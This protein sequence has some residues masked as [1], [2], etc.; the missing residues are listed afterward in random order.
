MHR[1]LSLRRERFRGRGKGLEGGVSSQRPRRPWNVRHLCRRLGEAAY[2]VVQ[3]RT[4]VRI[5]PALRRCHVG[6]LH[7]R[8]QVRD[9]K[10]HTGSFLFLKFSN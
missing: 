5:L 2:P 10:K 6:R 7:R 4:E 1:S 3:T 8:L 9:H